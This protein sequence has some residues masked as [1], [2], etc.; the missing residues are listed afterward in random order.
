MCVSE[1]PSTIAGIAG[2]VPVIIAGN[3]IADVCLPLNCV[4]VVSSCR[5]AGISTVSSFPSHR[6][7]A[8]V[9]GNASWEDGEEDEDEEAGE[10]VVGEVTKAVVV[11]DGDGA[12]TEGDEMDV[13]GLRMGAG[14]M[15]ED[16][17]EDIEGMDMCTTGRLSA[18]KVTRFTAGGASAIVMVVRAFFATWSPSSP[19][20]V[21]VVIEV[22][23][24]AAVAVVVVVVV[25][26]VGLGLGLGAAAVV[27]EA[28]FS[29]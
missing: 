27:D 18:G 12:A 26:V 4:L 5:F 20:A 23:V 3:S 10:D 6:F 19:L 16:D 17:E 15:V 11:G 13:L 29:H 14:R 7:V 21:F 28:L 1:L 2:A 8:V 25:V 24:A 9:G 22:F